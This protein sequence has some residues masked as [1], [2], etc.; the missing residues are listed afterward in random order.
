MN[1]SDSDVQPVGYGHGRC[2]LRRD[3]WMTWNVEFPYTLDTD[4]SLFCLG[5]R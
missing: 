4:P 5:S 3:F 2:V 1:R